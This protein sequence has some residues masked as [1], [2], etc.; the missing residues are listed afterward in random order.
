MFL[1]FWLVLVL[2]AMCLIAIILL[3]QPHHGH[4]EAFFYVPIGVILL[5]LASFIVMSVIRFVPIITSAVEDKHRSKSG[6][7]L[8][9]DE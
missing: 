4:N 1:I 7:P 8:N 3:V 6:L 5:T 9:P 2:E